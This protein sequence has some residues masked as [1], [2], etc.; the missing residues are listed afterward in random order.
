MPAPQR[1]GRPKG[2]CSRRWLYCS[3][4]TRKICRVEATARADGPGE[5]KSMSVETGRARAGEF[6]LDGQD[7]TQ[8]LLVTG[9]YAGG[10]S[11]DLALTGQSDVADRF[12]ARRFVG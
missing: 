3:G 6:V 1:P 11:L 5:L 2:A 9:H 7:A 10:Q 12:S 8:Q 4:G